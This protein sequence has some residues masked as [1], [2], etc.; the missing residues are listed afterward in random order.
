MER[1]EFIALISI[2]AAVLP[3]SA[4]AEGAALLNG[5]APSSATN[6]IS[7]RICGTWS[8][9]SSINTRRDGSTFDR[10]GESPK[11][12]FMF[13]H[14]GHYSQIIIGSESRVFGAKVF[15]AFG[16][17]SV[18]EAKKELITNVE[19]CSISRFVGTKQHRSILQLTTEY[20]KYVNPVTANGSTAEVL[21][22][23]LT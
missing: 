18:V 2:A 7:S 3:E 4:R 17:Y 13:D 8:F 9:A 1:R 14:G 11:G 19:A 12:I 16:T 10:W 6:T 21:W 23:R 5:P 20:L 15:C 22:K